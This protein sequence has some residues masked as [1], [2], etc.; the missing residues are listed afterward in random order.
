[1]RT[2]HILTWD[3]QGFVD[4]ETFESAD[5]ASQWFARAID[6][7][8][9]PCETCGEMLEPYAGDWEDHTCETSGPLAGQYVVVNR[10]S[11]TGVAWY[12]RDHSPHNDRVRAR[13]V[14]DDR[15]ETFDASDCTPIDEEDFCSGC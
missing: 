15:L 6:D 1:M 4:C 13:M 2:G 5:A 12:V 7:M 3:S 14:G 11:T 8:R 10:M 9:E